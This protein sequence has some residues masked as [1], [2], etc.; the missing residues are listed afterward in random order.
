MTFVSSTFFVF[1]LLA[2]IAYFI[3][4]LNYRWI[5]LLA[6]SILFYVSSG[7]IQG[8]FIVFSSLLTFFAARYMDDVYK[9]QDMQLKEAEL[10][11]EEKRTLK[12]K[13]KQKNKKILLITCLILICILLYCKIGNKVIAALQALFAAQSLDWMHVI[14]PL[15]ISYYT[16]SLISYLADIYWRK[17]KAQTNYF[18]FALFVLYFPKILQGP[19]SRHKNLENQLITGHSFDFTRVCY[20][21]QLAIWGYFKKIVIA[22][23]LV[24]FVNQVF[25]NC[26]E[27]SGLIFVIAAMAGSVQL[28][29]DFSGCMDI[30]SGISQIF[31]IELEK[32][33]DHPFFAKSAA[34]FWRRWHI[35]LGSWFKDYV[36]MPLVISPRVMKIGQTVRERIGKRAGKAVM[37]IIPLGCVWILT[38]LWHG[39]GYNYI[40]W[41]LYWGVIIIISTVFAPEIKK[42]TALLRINTEAGSWKV[43]QMVRTFLLYSFGRLITL[44]EHLR[45][46]WDILKRIVSKFDIWILFDGSLCNYGLDGKDLF[47]AVISIVILWS[48]SMLQRNGSLR[49][50]IAGNNLV[51]RWL[52]YYIAIFSIIVFGIYGPG[53]NSS[54]FI[55]MN[56]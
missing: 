17:D 20:G 42:L 55:Y 50:K 5:A 45:T 36:Y 35:T 23:R 29:C 56:Y 49:E 27:Y 13:V 4:P 33:F 32:N 54:T 2:V 40:A 10:T 18:K 3:I 12:A 31:G 24:I 38:G 46:T 25:D 47:I 26:Y 44:P 43:W 9:K 37:S 1:I 19:I 7:I 11:A 48:V 8:V 30:A 53:Y 51:I 39:T 16:F 6:A 21:C 41:G 15:G 52:I 14:V 28:Y 22:D 34:E